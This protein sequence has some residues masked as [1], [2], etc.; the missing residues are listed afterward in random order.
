[1][2][3][4]ILILFSIKLRFLKPICRPRNNPPEPIGVRTT[5]G[6]PNSS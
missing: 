2:K 1:M 5:S 3:Y 4:G 6:T